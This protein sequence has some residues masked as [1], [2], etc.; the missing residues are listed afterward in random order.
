MTEPP[1]RSGLALLGVHPDETS[2][3]GWLAATFFVIQTTH[4]L[5]LNVADALFFLRFGVDHLPLM[6]LVS[7]GVVMLA[8]FGYLA[9][10]S[11]FG[12]RRWM[13]TVPMMSAGWLVVERVGIALDVGSIYPV[14][15][16]AA[17]VLMMVT[18]TLMW[19]A[20]AEV[21][22]TRQ[23]KRL[24]PLFASAGIA[25]GI[26]GNALTG[27][28]AGLL[29]T[30]NVL[31]VQAG[32]LTAGG[33]LVRE[34]AH[35]FFD[36]GSSDVRPGPL[37]GLRE[38]FRLT[39]RTPLLRL[40]A[41][42][43]LASS[44]LLF[45][46]VFPFSEV[47]AASFDTE[48]GVATYLGVFSALAT[49]ATLIVSL[50]L[51]N[52]LF[53]RLG[54][55][56]T[57]LVMPLTYLA[58]FSLWAIR[59]DLVTASIVRGAQW[60]ALNALGATALNSLF[61]VVRGTRRAQVIAFVNAV[62]TQ[63]GT[64]AAGILLLAAGAASDRVRLALSLGVAAGAVTVA[65]R[66]RGAYVDALVSAVD[67]GL[68]D[69]FTAP[70]PGLQKPDLDADTRTALGAGLDHPDPARRKATIVML[71][72]LADDSTETLLRSRLEDDDPS[73]RLAALDALLD[74]GEH[75][76]IAVD[77]LRDPAGEV[78]LYAARHLLRIPHGVEPSAFEPLLDDANAEVRGTGAVLVGGAR[79]A[80]TVSALLADTDPVAIRSGLEAAARGVAA[81][82]RDVVR[83]ADHPDAGVRQAAAQAMADRD[84]ADGV[85]INLLDDVSP[86]VRETAAETLADRP[87]GSDR[88]LE[89]LREG[90]VR[91]SE[92]AL[93][94]LAA[95]EERSA[96]G[97]WIDGELDR[98]AFLHRMRTSFGRTADRDLPTALRYLVRVL[99]S[100][101]RRLE[102]WVLEALGAADEM[103]PL[104][105]VSRG[106]WSDD[107]ETRSQALEA[108]ESMTHR[109]EARRLIALLEDDSTEDAPPP[110]DALWSL[111]EDFDPWIRSLAIRCLETE[112]TRDMRRLSDLASAKSEPTVATR[113]RESETDRA[114]PLGVL[115]TVL[116]LQE[117]GLFADLDPEE[118][119]LVAEVTEERSY[120]A[121]EV[122]Y[123][124]GA[125]GSEMLVIVDGDV[126]VR[127]DGSG[128]IVRTPGEYVGEL[129]ILRNRPRMA[130]VIAGSKGTRGIVVQGNELR[131]IL[132]ERPEAMLAMLRTLAE[133]VAEVAS[134]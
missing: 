7:G 86:T 123:R 74:G 107:A 72:R 60:V 41:V 93:P 82:D 132:E 55:V 15:W 44:T 35:R 134:R 94:V 79:G 69:V 102:R 14:V 133:R 2:M 17:Q 78:R 73:V 97:P 53:A 108:L 22:T 39:L 29:G 84:D 12:D 6:I 27:P 109:E 56:T 103:P 38:G 71:S 104:D 37:E 117:V 46:V 85:L 112:L 49:V 98:A 95:S 64:S 124:A 87:G 114:R 47:V 59:F 1:R 23:A 128:R 127:T 76:E 48:A 36:S 119:E 129:A 58:G 40:A 28:L 100:R 90:S 19:T 8:M 57:F 62:P 9:S 10:L 30:E 116:A 131:S 91:A 20:A 68:V 126:E 75:P 83:F 25:G 120:G 31:L 115:D 32:L 106:A 5:G 21:C 101:E 45:L 67:R 65:F 81:P 121:G 80:S 61:N 125:T 3:A 51:A 54:V 96:L 4:G 88:L 66:M 99:T 63:M 24:Y 11:W 52:R 105:T 50:F 18:F 16:Q 42:A 122:V 33:W 77:A 118:L 92:A 89:V 70:V 26:L 34:T 130:T 43:S 113:F 13:W 110:R 111:T